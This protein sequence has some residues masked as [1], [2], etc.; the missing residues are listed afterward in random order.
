ML[1]PSFSCASNLIFSKHTLSAFDGRFW[2]GG[3]GDDSITIIN[4]SRSTIIVDSIHVEFDTSLYDTFQ[5]G[6]MESRGEVKTYKIFNSENR[7]SLKCF[8][9]GISLKSYTE[10]EASEK[11]TVRVLEKLIIKSPYLSRNCSIVGVFIDC[12]GVCDPV[13]IKNSYFKGRLI[14]FSENQPDTIH[15]NCQ[16]TSFTTKAK[17]VIKLTKNSVSNNTA[18]SFNILGRKISPSKK[19]ETFHFLKTHKEKTVRITHY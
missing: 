12:F 9:K 4:K 8:H 6:W 3:F 13:I 7:D 11:I 2:N 16:I 14:F 19:L 18:N 1:I 10:S 15:L 17:S 5:I